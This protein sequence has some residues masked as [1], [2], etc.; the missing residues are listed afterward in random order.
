M[1][2]AGRGSLGR[3]AHMKTRALIAVLLLVFSG[4]ASVY[5]NYRGSDSSV[6]LGDMPSLPKTLTF[7]DEAGVLVRSV[8]GMLSPSP[9]APLTGTDGTRKVEVSPGG[10]RLNIT[11]SGGGFPPKTSYA[12]L[13]LK[14][15]ANHFYRL[16]AKRKGEEILLQVWDETNGFETRRLQEE[17]TIMPAKT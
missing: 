5:V 1:A 3:S 10:H 13:D 12:N 17:I 15:A 7:S 16:T 2:E 6:V 14:I 11:V 9:F 4:C 8:D